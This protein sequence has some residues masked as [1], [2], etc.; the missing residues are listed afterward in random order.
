MAERLISQQL[1]CVVIACQ[2]QIRYIMMEVPEGKR[3]GAPSV[4][5]MGPG[6]PDVETV[7]LS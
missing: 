5:Q 4:K 2:E 7:V 3:G 1:V 6:G